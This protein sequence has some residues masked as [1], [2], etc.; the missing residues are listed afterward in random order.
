MK[1]LSASVLAMTASLLLGTGASASTSALALP[2]GLT[3]I[4]YNANEDRRR[5]EDRL[6]ERAREER[7][8]EPRYSVGDRVP[9]RFLDREVSNWRAERLS[10]PPR[11]REWVRL[12]D[13]FMLVRIRDQRIERVVDPDRRGPRFR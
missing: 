12:G 3:N 4:Q 7:R 8:G 1:I 6:R 11:G 13:R 10:R 9:E 2:S 5:D